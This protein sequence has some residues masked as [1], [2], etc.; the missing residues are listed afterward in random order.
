ME[1]HLVKFS[2]GFRISIDDGVEYTPLFRVK[3]E[4]EKTGTPP[5]SVDPIFRGALD[6]EQNT[7]FESETSINKDEAVEESSSGQVHGCDEANW[8]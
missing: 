5:I 7:Y 3:E 8:E 6:E 2:D 4:S 1:Q